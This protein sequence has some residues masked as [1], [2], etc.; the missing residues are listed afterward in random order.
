MESS[1]ELSVA[2]LEVSGDSEEDSEAVSSVTVEARD[3]EEED[4]ESCV[5]GAGEDRSDT[6]ERWSTWMQ[7]CKQTAIE[8]EK[9][10]ERSGCDASRGG[11]RTAE[12]E[13]HRLFWEACLANEYSSHI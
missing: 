2:P 7:W 3:D 13:D 1:H 6:D 11:G 9:T 8:Y 10:V 5:D 12:M 4:A